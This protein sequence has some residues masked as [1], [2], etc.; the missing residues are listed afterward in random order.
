MRPSLLEPS[1]LRSLAA[2]KLVVIALAATRLEHGIEG[3][4]MDYVG[5]AAAAGASWA[6]VPGPGE[7][8]LIA[9]GVVAAK[10]KLDIAVVISVAFGGAIIGGVLGWVVGRKA[11]RKVLSRPGPLLGFRRAALRK[12]DE[13]F[14]RAPVIAVFL[15]PTWVAG[16]HQVKSGI[17]LGTTLVGAIL[18]ASGIGLSSYYVGP[19]VLDIVNDVGWVMGLCLVVLIVSVVCLEA[20]RRRRQSI[21]RAAEYEAHRGLDA[22]VDTS[23]AA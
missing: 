9:A 1:V 6:G 2:F 7:P 19:K 15:T 11:G 18:W 8:V 12:G 3:N 22:D 23:G 14:K 21:R 17:F 10:N 13:I 20:V 4:P 5:L 16:I